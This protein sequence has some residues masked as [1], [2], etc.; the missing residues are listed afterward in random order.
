MLRAFYL[1]PL[2]LLAALATARENAHNWIEVRSPGFTI[3]TDSSEKQGRRIASQFERMRAIFQQ[4]YPDR[5][6][7][8]ESPVVVLALRS[9][10][11]F[12]ALEPGAYLSR[13]SLPLHG[14]F[15]RAAD[16]NY[17][18]MR[19]DSQAG[20]PYPLVYHEYAHLY[21]HQ[22]DER[23]PLWL[24]EGLAEFYQST[25][26]YDRD[27]LLGPVDQQH[28]MLLRHEELLPLATLF[29]VD[30]KSPY[31]LEEKK[32]HI[33]YAECWA[34]AHYLTLQDYAEKTTKVLQ[35][36]SLVNANVDPVTAAVRVFGDLRKLQRTLE[37][38]IAQTSFNHFETKIPGTVNNLQFD[39]KSITAAQAQA[40]Q[41][42]FLAASGR[43]E[44]ARA[45]FP[46]AAQDRLSP[47]ENLPLD[48][49]AGRAENMLRSAIRSDVPCPLAEILQGASQRATEMVD[50]LQRFTA[51]E[52]ILHTEFKKN[53]TPRKATNQLFSYLAEI[54]SAPTG[55]FWVEE[56]RTSKTEGDSPPI[57]DT[58]TAAFALIF[59]PQKIGNFQFRCEG[60]TDIQGTPAWQL[61]FEE[62]SDPNRSFHQ[63]R[64]NH[65]VYPLRFQGRAWIA[66]DSHQILRLQT[67]LVMPIPQIHLEQEHLDITYAAVDFDKS[68]FTVWLP[69]SA[70]MQISYRGH[71]YQRIHKFSHFQLFLVVTEEKV[72]EPVPAL[73][74]NRS[75]NLGCSFR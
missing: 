36:T 49:S 28:L 21:L 33:F 24:N 41:A 58:G 53:G 47:S 68:R 29:T 5:D 65:A 2:L 64:I 60:L 9:K 35:Y 45:L 23:L 57:S 74:Q 26:I 70:S 3:V 46:S 12:R 50:N 63:I 67:D 20:N 22:S 39:V 40:R 56:Y 69:E 44:Q 30:E 14:I 1:A 54:D 18:L 38:Y 37:L 75:L 59:H 17:I 19:L 52:A 27:V 72:K 25:E 73:A 71:R 62:S 13:N 55:A 61:R 8:A 11:Q 10:E 6:D 43:A 31:Y 48:Q 7:D 15:V 42:A 51:S 16:T 34:L 32:G 4:A 66:S